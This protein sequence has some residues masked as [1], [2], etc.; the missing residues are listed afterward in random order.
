[1]CQNIGHGGQREHVVDDGGFAEQPFQRRQRRLGAHNAALAFQAFQQRGFFA[2]NIGSGPQAHFQMEGMLAAQHR[3]ADH[4][5]CLGDADRALQG[6]ESVRVFG[7]QIDVT[8]RGPHR[9]AGN[10]HALDEG[11]RVALHQHAVGKRAAIA[12]IGVADDVFARPGRVV[13]G[14]PFDPGGESRAAATAQAAL[15]DRLHNLLRAQRLR[16]PQ[17]G[18]TAMGAVIV[19][20]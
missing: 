13:H 8:A 15:L 1:M 18:Q 10:R 7:A 12:L 2:A 9:D 5:L 16:R 20:R 14:L 4:A 11:E 3:R 6:A 19:H 17:T